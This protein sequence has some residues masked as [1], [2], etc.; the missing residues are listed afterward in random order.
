MFSYFTNFRWDKF[1]LAKIKSH[2]HKLTCI[3]LPEPKYKGAANDRRPYVGMVG[4]IIPHEEQPWNIPVIVWHCRADGNI[5]AEW[6]LRINAAGTCLNEEPRFPSDH[7]RHLV[8]TGNE[9]KYPMSRASRIYI[10]ELTHELWT[11]HKLTS[12]YLL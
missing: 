9:I 10:N 2:Q 1:A 12:K 3:D 4:L 7:Q 11:M 8:V 6:T 5:W